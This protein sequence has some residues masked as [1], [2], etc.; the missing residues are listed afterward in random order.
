ML[1]DGVSE[2][3]ALNV[4]RLLDEHGLL[5]GAGEIDGSRLLG[6]AEF[7]ELMNRTP[8]IVR[9]W[10]HA[11]APVARLKSGP[12]WDRLHAEAFRDAHPELC[13]VRVAAT[14]PNPPAVGRG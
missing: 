12:V 8:Q 2:R 7:A 4:W 13:G 10:R 1:G 9:G 5:D 6:L 3:A 11:P 14:A